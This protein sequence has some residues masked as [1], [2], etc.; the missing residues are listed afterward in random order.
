MS[1]LNSSFPEPIDP[2]NS[3]HQSSEGYI[4]AVVDQIGAPY[5][6]AEAAVNDAADGFI[7]LLGEGAV[8]EA[9][10]IAESAPLT[11]ADEAGLYLGD[12]FAIEQ[13]APSAGD[14]AEKYLDVEVIPLRAGD[15]I[16]SADIQGSA[17]V[18]W[19]FGPTIMKMVEDIAVAKPRSTEPTP[20]PTTSKGWDALVSDLAQSRTGFTVEKSRETLESEQQVQDY[21]QFWGDDGQPGNP[22]AAQT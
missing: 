1:E 5:E 16:T 10:Y 22:P 11:V 20:T 7:R 13:D 15:P 14:L 9:K 17:D 4:G 8:Q 3:A 2:Q 19:F 21:L 12:L 6:H 18:K